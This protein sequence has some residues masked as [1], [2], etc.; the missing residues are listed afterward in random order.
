MTSLECE[1]TIHLMLS[2]T[3]L[4]SV[5]H[6]KLLTRQVLLSMTELNLHKI[7]S[8][9]ELESVPSSILLNLHLMLRVT[10]LESVSHPKLLTRQVQ[11]LLSMSELNSHLIF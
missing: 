5:S 1:L 11:V 8:V 10:G 9:T 7:F 3:S 4:E 6:S 2:I